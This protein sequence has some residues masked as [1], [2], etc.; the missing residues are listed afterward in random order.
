MI[1]IFHLPKA[2]SCLEYTKKSLKPNIR[3]RG[4]TDNSTADSLRVL[5]SAVHAWSQS[6]QQRFCS[7]TS[8]PPIREKALPR[9]K[10]VFDNSANLAFPQP[11]LCLIA[12]TPLKKSCL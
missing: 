1:L 10:P 12:S 4:V 5:L 8:L 6:I 2:A 7:L 3:K 9:Q 11:Q